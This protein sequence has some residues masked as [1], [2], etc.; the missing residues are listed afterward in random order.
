MKTLFKTTITALALVVFIGCKEKQS[1]EINTPEEVKK[2]AERT[3]DIANAEFID[4][5]TGKIWHN[6]L[7]IKM[8][9]TESDADHVQDVANSMAESFSEERA[10]MKALAQQMSETDDIEAQRELF[11]QFTENAGPIFEDALSGGTIY[12]KFCP[13][14]FLIKKGLIG[15]P[16]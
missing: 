14:A 10:V 6:Y 7:E 12:K 8:A 5:M 15:M 3:P 11:A 13:M 9:L 16:V 1:V 2:E 4:G